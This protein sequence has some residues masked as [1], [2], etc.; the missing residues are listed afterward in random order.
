M[1]NNIIDDYHASSTD[2]GVIGQLTVW[3]DQ[4]L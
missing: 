1:N 4:Q 3:H 2:H